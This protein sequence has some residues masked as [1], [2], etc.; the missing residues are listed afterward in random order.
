MKKLVLVGAGSRGLS[1]YAQPITE[2]YADEATILGVFDTNISRALLLS[3][4]TGGTIPVYEDFDR[5][6]AEVKP[7]AVIVTTVDR[8]HHQYIIAALEAGCD[9][10]SEK[11]MTI[12]ADKCRAILEAERR[13]G[14]KV[15]VTFNARCSPFAT[16]IKDLMRAGAVGQV[17]SVHFEWFLDTVHG[18]DYFRR[19]HRRLEN[20]GG[21]L[22]HK[23]THHFDLVNWF[24]EK[25]PVAVFATGSRRFYG[26]PS[27]ISGPRCRTCAHKDDCRFFIDVTDPAYRELYFDCETADGYWRDGCVFS[28]EIDIYDTMTLHVQ[29]E[30]QISMAY[31]L[32]A[33]SP[34]EGYRLVINGERGRLEA[35]TFAHRYNVAQTSHSIKVLDRDNAV[36]THQVA[37]LGGTHGGADAILMR[38]LMRDQTPDPH[39]YVAGSR[40]G[41]MSLII[42]AA[43]NLSIASGRVIQVKDLLPTL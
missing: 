25:D 3:R 26:Q 40:S 29:Y 6:L 9:A 41:A 32:T 5:M 19:W 12:D 33:H 34:H 24:I 22:V 2:L 13:T 42:G 30:D 1:M 38:L 16:K 11:P 21:L 4:K 18:A 39:Q 28:P 7:D 43:A 15:I 23:A 14:R 36:I 17:Y 8:F 27:A 35:E 31:S 37:K 10:I 20:S